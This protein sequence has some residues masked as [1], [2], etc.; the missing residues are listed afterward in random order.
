MSRS[1]SIF[2]AGDQRVFVVNNRLD[3]F[4]FNTAELRKDVSNN[5]VPVLNNIYAQMGATGKAVVTISGGSVGILPNQYV[6]VT[7]G[8]TGSVSISSM[9]AV[10]ISGA[11]GVTGS[12]GL[13]PNQYVGITGG[14]TGTVSLAS[15]QSVS[16]SG[17]VT[18]SFTFA[19]GSYVGITGL[20][21]TN[22]TSANLKLTTIETDISSG[23]LVKGQDDVGARYPLYTDA[24]GTQRTQIL[25]GHE[26]S[27]KYI[28]STDLAA[29][30]S[31]SANWAIDTRGR[32]G[33][34]YSGAST[35]LSWYSNSISS[36]PSLDFNK[37]Q[38]VWMNLCCD[39]TAAIPSFVVETSLSIWY[40][41]FT[42][43]TSVINGETYCF[44]YGNKALTLNP[45]YHPLQM[46]RTLSFGPGGNNEPI[47]S[48]TVQ[49]GAA[50]NF[51]IVSAG[52]WNQTLLQEFSVI[53]DN[54]NDYQEQQKILSLDIDAV[55]STLK[56]G[57][58]GNEAGITAGTVRRV[59]VVGQIAN[60]GF[61]TTR[62]G[63]ATD[64]LTKG[65][66]IITVD[67]LYPGQR[68]VTA[69][70]SSTNVNGIT[71]QNRVALTTLVDN[72]VAYPVNA[73]LTGTN[74]VSLTG[75]NYVNV[76]GGITG[77]V[78]LATGTVVGITGSIGSITIPAGAVIGI[79]G[80]ITG[81]VNILN[82]PVT[83][84]ITGSVSVTGGITGSVSVS[85]FPTLQ[86][87]TGS[88]G[89]LPNQTVGITGYL[90]TNNYS[91]VGLN[92]YNIYPKTIVYNM[93]GQNATAA[94]NQI[95]GGPSCN[96]TYILQGYGK[97]NPRTWSATILTGGASKT[98]SYDYVNTSGD[99]IS[100][101]G[102]TVP[103][104]SWVSLATNIISINK[105]SINATLGT[106]DTL[107]M[108]T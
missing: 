24:N 88:V 107:I 66:N 3:T 30:A 8:I 26:E 103:V 1:S 73:T 87:I 48:I 75:T 77:T 32:D 34:Y 14:I 63:I 76:S 44:Y 68:A 15:G 2:G 28:F 61:S 104:N 42:T 85:N 39:S 7:G 21:Q 10:T 16:I 11:V 40:Y 78:S 69:E 108:A 59:N 5:I 91:A 79:T 23:I 19:N 52:I 60:P 72:P 18:G 6:G 106:A 58:Y 99:L 101:T 95:L 41:T 67:S 81:D 17:G 53:F 29:I 71:G 89:I 97:A 98:L 49:S 64:S 38:A 33:W 12:V 50:T 74:Y 35:A 65:V 57:I 22:D 62:Y 94:L 37:M 27:A 54:N 105:W 46:T 13:L 84:G 20:V 51:L 47:T 96:L 80:G 83:Q 82:F 43:L 45:S 36:P 4:D 92:T 100:V 25:T 31:P 55:G 70:I 56:T 90:T 102:V 86:G 9:P 93:N